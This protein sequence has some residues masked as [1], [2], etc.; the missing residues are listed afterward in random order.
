MAR[1]AGGLPDFAGSGAVVALDP[2][3]AILTRF[4]VGPSPSHLLLLP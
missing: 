1:G 2:A 4:G 3:G